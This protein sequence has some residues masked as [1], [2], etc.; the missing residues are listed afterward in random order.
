MNAVEN[1]ASWDLISP[2]TG[3]IEST[4]DA[5]DLFKKMLIT[6]METGEPYMLFK[7]NVN[8]LKPEEYI[9][10]SWDVS[11]SNL[12][13]EITLHTEEDYT[14]VCCL[15]SLN[16]EYWMEYQ[17]DIY[18]IVYDCQRFLDNVLQDFINLTKGKPGFT[19]SRKSAEYERSLG[20]GVMGFHSLLQKSS[21]P[22]SSP[23]TKGLNL[24][25]FNKIKAW[26]KGSDE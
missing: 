16:L 23:M 6:R 9:R 14:G 25:I 17:I 1:R 22:W 19:S 18:Q 10:N 11:M 5:Y 12:C 20:L 21:M 26:L 4:V 7:N 13:A 2:K 3:K 24:Q 8:N 15:A